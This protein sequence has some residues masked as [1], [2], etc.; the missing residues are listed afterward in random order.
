MENGPTVAGKFPAEASLSPTETAR[1]GAALAKRTYSGL[2]VLLSGDL[3]AGKTLLAQSIGSFLGAEGMRSPTFNI[4]LIHRLPGRK[5]SLAHFDLYRLESMGHEDIDM[6]SGPYSG[7][8]DI[9][10]QMEERIEDGDL[11][12]VEWGE[13]WTSPPLSDRWDVNISRSAGKTRSIELSAFGETALGALACA[14]DE[15]LDIASA[16]GAG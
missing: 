7:D 5:F 1:F 16:V 4:E 14:Y 15:I 10:M 2:L 13:R 3:G 8:S 12:L 9:V 6:P 11:V